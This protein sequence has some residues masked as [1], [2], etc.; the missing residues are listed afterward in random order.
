MA[1]TLALNFL[2]AGGGIGWLWKSGKLDREKV[3]AMREMVFPTTGPATRAAGAELA[4]ATTR[5]ML[6]LEE[7]LEKQ[8]GRPATEQ[9]AYMQTAFDAQM[10]QLDRRQQELLGLQRQVDLAQQQ[11][12]KDRAALEAEKKRLASRE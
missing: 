6:R 4:M 11:M 9:V 10:A 1:W 12:S 8:A 7:L 3:Q 2:A 5:P